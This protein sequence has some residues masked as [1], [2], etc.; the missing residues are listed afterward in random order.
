M[1]YHRWY[2]HGD[3]NKTARESSITA[4][5]GRRYRTVAAKGHPMAMKNGRAYEHRKVL[6]DDIGHGIHHCHWCGTEVEWTTKG[7]PRELHPDH[8][9]GDGS[10]NRLENLVPACRRCNAARGSQARHDALRD[11]GWWSGNDTIAHLKGG[12]RA[13]RIQEPAA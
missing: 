11:A 12:G 4:S 7:D 10:D 6:F 8:L 9:N 3:V 13:P 2:R 5:L 1:H